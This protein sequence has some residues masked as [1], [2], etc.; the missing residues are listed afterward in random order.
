M[1]AMTLLLWKA[2]QDSKMAG[3]EEF[4]LG[5]S[6]LD[7]KGLVSFKDHW[8]ERRAQLVTWRYPAPDSLAIREAW[9]LKVAQSIF[10]CM[11]DR[12]LAMTGKLIYR[13]IG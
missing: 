5:R 9:K 8:V 12:L 13:H 10:A 1:G 3:A 11:P 6:E 2:I 4:D 7:N